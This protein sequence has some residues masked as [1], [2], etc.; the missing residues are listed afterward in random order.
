MKSRGRV[1]DD[2]SLVI[3]PFVGWV[4]AHIPQT[5]DTE[6]ARGE[7]GMNPP[8]DTASSSGT[9]DVFPV[10]DAS[11]LPYL[12]NDDESSSSSSDND[13]LPPAAGTARCQAGAHVTGPCN[14]DG[15][16]GSRIQVQTRALSTQR[17]TRLLTILLSTEGGKVA[18]TLIAEQGMS[19]K[20]GALPT[21]PVPEVEPDLMP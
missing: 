1:D 18:R 10:P 17:E 3:L 9:E 16:K 14:S 20:S 12:S 7:S 13:D 2:D 15:I 21:C 11:S 4:F 8:A 6:S 5:T 19:Q